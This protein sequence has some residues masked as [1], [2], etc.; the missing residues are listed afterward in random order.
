METTYKTSELELASFLK[1]DFGFWIGDR[2]DDGL[3]R[4]DGNLTGLG[5]DLD[6]NIFSLPE[7]FLGSHL[8][9]CFD[10]PD[11]SALLDA[12]LPTKFIDD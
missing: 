10:R 4:H 8:K 11:H 3:L 5:V 12:L 6:L 9:G 7:T 1:R 2:V